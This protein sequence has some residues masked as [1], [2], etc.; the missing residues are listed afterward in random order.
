MGFYG[1]GPQDVA[2]FFYDLVGSHAINQYITMASLTDAQFGYQRPQ[3]PLNIL[4]HQTTGMML[5][6]EPTT[7]F[8]MS[9]LITQ[10]TDMLQ[11]HTGRN[12][13]AIQ[14]GPATQRDILVT[15]IGLYSGV[16][17]DHSVAF[18]AGGVGTESASFIFNNN[19]FFNYNNGTNANKDEDIMYVPSTGMKLNLGGL[20]GTHSVLSANYS[21]KFNW[22]KRGVV[23]DGVGLKDYILELARPIEFSASVEIAQHDYLPQTG[24][25]AEGLLDYPSTWELNIYGGSP[26]AGSIR[27]TYT[28]P[29]ARLVSETMGYSDNGIPTVTLQYQ[30]VA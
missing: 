6:G 8:S 16:I 20:V 25:T 4:G 11:D 21:T 24:A 12:D 9:K 29:N 26:W 28:V 14:I 15:G 1:L 19:Q 18:T 2:V 27:M 3:Q 10:E 30:G 23:S 5:G 17:T 7:S 22:I 13:L